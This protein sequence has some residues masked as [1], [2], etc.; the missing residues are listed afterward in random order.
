MASVRRPTTSGIEVRWP[1][2]LGVEADR[3]TKGRQREAEAERVVRV[4]EQL[5]AWRGLP[6]A[7]RCDNGPELL[8]GAFVVREIACQCMIEYNEQPL[9]DAL[10]KV[11]P[12]AFR[13][14]FEAENSTFEL[15]S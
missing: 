8:S 11:P 1:V 9:H 13:D 10:G 2:G 5:K 14:R 12:A 15:S 4:M 6:Q 3:G 7:I